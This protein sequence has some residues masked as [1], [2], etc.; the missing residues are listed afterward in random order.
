VARL[1]ELVQ[2]PK[3]NYE[4]WLVE[5]KRVYPPG[6]LAAGGPIVT[7]RSDSRFGRHV[8][9]SQKIAGQ[10]PSTDP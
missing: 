1:A 4:R 10:S 2:Q 3:S 9:P 7:I 5:V 6:W 8:L